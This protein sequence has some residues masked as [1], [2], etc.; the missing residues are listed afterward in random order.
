M[1]YR[2][3]RAAMEE[4]KY[5]E[6]IQKLIEVLKLYDATLMRPYRSYYDCV[7]DLRRCMLALG[8]YSIV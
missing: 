1:L 2:L 5:G 7:Q 6:A 3:G 4:G 8:N